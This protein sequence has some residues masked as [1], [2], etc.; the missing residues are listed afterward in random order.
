MA[1]EVRQY[2]GHYDQT[3]VQRLPQRDQHPRSTSGQNP[4]PSI[5]ISSQSSSLSVGSADMLSCQRIA[6]VTAPGLPMRQLADIATTNKGSHGHQISDLASHL[7]SQASARHPSTQQNY[8]PQHQ[9][10]LQH[11][12][13]LQH[14]QQPRN[15]QQANAKESDCSDSELCQIAQHH[16]ATMQTQ[17]SQHPHHQHHHHHH[18]HQQQQQQQQ[19]QN[20]LMY[21]RCS[22][23]SSY[24]QTE[25]QQA[26]LHL[27][28]P[29][30]VGLMLSSKEEP[31]LEASCARPD[32]R[33][34]PGLAASKP[35]RSGLS[36][37]A[38]STSPVPLA[39]PLP[40]GSAMNEAVL[41]ANAAAAAV[42]AAYHSAAAMAAAAVVAQAAVAQATATGGGSGSS[43]GPGPGY[44]TDP[45]YPGSPGLSG[46][47]LGL[48][49]RT[50]TGS[51][52][53][54][55]SGQG[56]SAGKTSKSKKMA[57]TGE[58][59]ISLDSQYRTE[60]TEVRLGTTAL[61]IVG[62]LRNHFGF[63]SLT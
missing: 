32:G 38:G 48:P 15:H 11:Q 33:L 55:L 50:S 44:S 49:G 6:P 9:H 16:L 53:G 14:Q 12:L 10:Q 34:S 22:V 59:S 47:G 13:Q 39:S 2:D 5:G 27:A 45:G 54:G 52:S 41:S 63:P 62:K 18:H 19:Q 3:A 1:E 28:Q 21:A 46:C 60:L 23:H 24:G 26:G 57:S 4:S 61:L 51:S 56:L 36:Q 35:L 31:G 20:Q 30:P 17:N 43:S 42:S 25:H 7:Q 37:P 40:H 29:P 8:A 58:R